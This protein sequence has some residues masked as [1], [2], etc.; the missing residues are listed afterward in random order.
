MFL[1]IAAISI[2][3]ITGTIWLFNRISPFR[4]CPICAG[5]SGT[6]LWMLAA[7]FSGYK[8][9]SVILAILMGGTVVGLAYQI[10]K[11]LPAE[12]SPL[13]FK[14]LFI[15]TGFIA[16]HGLISRQWIVFIASLLFLLLLSLIFLLPRKNTEIKNKKVAELEQKMKS[17]C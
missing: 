16:T 9:D 4:V 7:Y 6:W 5:V 3:V 17:C 2:L 14:I 15:P 13:P 11:R 12:K 10:E 8:I 1:T